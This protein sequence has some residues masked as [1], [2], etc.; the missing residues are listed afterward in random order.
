MEVD[1]STKYCGLTLK[2]PII[3]GS[4]TLNSNIDF[5]KQAQEAGVGAIVLKSIFEEEIF[6]Q[7][8]L[9]QKKANTLGIDPENLDYL[10]IKIR[11]D[12]LANYLKLIKEAKNTT[13]IPIIASINCVSDSEWISYAKEIENA[14]ADAIELNIFGLQLIE[15]K[16]SAETEQIYINI[17]KSIKQ[18]TKIPVIA[19]IPIY[20]SNPFYTLKQ[21]SQAG[22]DGLVLFNRFYN[23][24]IDIDKKETNIS[25]ILSSNNEYLNSLRWIALLSGRINCSLCASTGIHDAHTA[26]KLLLAGANAIQIVSA[27]YLNGLSIIKNINEAISDYLQKN[28]Y[29]ALFQ[30]Q[31]LLSQKQIQNPETYARFQFMKYYNKNNEY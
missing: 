3:V 4:C 16:T 6:A 31:G 7:Y 1:I 11:Q 15:N 18:N 28:N 30:I 21:M 22:A 13:K 27:I 25:N 29:E 23:I 2:S 5:I 24:D 9:I 14:G 19:K 17:I 10:D 12:N 8:N 20:F 26:I